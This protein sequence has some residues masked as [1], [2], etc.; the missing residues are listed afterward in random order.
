MFILIIDVSKSLYI[1]KILYI[2]Q[3]ELLQHT[4]KSNVRK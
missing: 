4:E 2:I 1:L 3:M